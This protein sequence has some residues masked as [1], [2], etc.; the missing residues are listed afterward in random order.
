M[1]QKVA[2]K[3]SNHWLHC[4]CRNGE[5]SIQNNCHAA[6]DKTRSSGMELMSQKSLKEHVPP[7]VYDLANAS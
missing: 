6:H 5:D 2:S 4:T 7:Y 3:I 1:K